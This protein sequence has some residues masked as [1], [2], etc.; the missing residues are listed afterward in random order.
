MGRIIVNA[1]DFGLNSSCSL[2]IKEAFEKGIISSTTACANGE[3]ITEAYQL[4][5]EHHFED[6]VGIHINLTEGIPMTDKIKQDSFFCENGQFH[7]RINRFQRLNSEQI[8]E[9]QCE[10]RAQVEYLRKLGFRLTHADSHHHIHTAVNLEKAIQQ[11]LK[12][13]GINKLRLHRNVGNISII[14]RVV[15]KVYN[16]LL[17]KRRFVTVDKF[18]SWEDYQNNQKLLQTNFCE[19]MLHPDYDKDGLLI[20]RIEVIEDK[21]KGMKL[22]EISNMLQ[23]HTLVSYYEV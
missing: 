9:V 16:S 1:D 18:G 8:L 3:Y 14:K 2:A 15:K 12:E 5:C 17:N 22:G 10:V 19:I 21:N 23:G 20:D 13:Q 11:V 7:N 4:A 6:K